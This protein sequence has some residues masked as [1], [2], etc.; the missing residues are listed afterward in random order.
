M[1]CLEIAGELDWFDAVFDLDVY[2]RERERYLKRVARSRNDLFQ[3]DLQEFA[4]ERK[5]PLPRQPVLRL[6]RERLRPIVGH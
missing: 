6:I 3:A 4:R 2:G 1:L 5:F